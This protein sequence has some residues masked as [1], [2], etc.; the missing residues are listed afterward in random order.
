MSRSRLLKPGFFADANLGR[1]SRDSR[2]AFGGICTE[3]D[4]QGYFEWQPEELAWTLFRY[5]PDK[6]EVLDRALLELTSVGVVEHLPCGRHGLIDSMPE[7]RIQGG[8]HSS[9]VERQHRSGCLSGRVRTD[10]DTP[11]RAASP[12]V[13]VPVRTPKDTLVVGPPVRTSPDESLSESVSE[14]LKKRRKKNVLEEGVEIRDEAREPASVVEPPAH[15]SRPVVDDRTNASPAA[16]EIPAVTVSPPA[17]L[18]ALIPAW[19]TPPGPCKN[20]VAHQS[21]HRLIDGQAVCEA[22]LEEAAAALATKSNGVDHV[23]PGLEL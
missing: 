12:D 1:V 14:S 6:R 10:R 7:H 9:N 11:A 2:L 15:L 18:A 19:R 17:R 23:Q 4:D 5:D 21:K 3:A 8:N 20:Y 22:C 16:V 13:S